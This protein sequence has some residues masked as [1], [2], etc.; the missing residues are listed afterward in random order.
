MKADSRRRAAVL[1]LT[2]VAGGASCINGE[3]LTLP[4]GA[5][6]VPEDQVQT[7]VQ[8]VAS[9][10]DARRRGVVRTA[11]E[12]SAFW[13]EVYAGRDPVPERPDVDFD[14][15]MVI[16]AAMG[17]RPSG[18]YLVAFETIGRTGADYHVVVRETSPGRSC[19]TTAALTQP[20]VA[21]R[22]ARSDGN[23]SFIERTTTQR[24]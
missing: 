2:L 23:V 12:W 5:S 3:G 16:V 4:R 22:V 19:M 13:S 24:C 8:E 10:I 21:V 9:G 18:G 11:D 1:A 20:V 15:N 17:T 14:Q 6:R 7:L